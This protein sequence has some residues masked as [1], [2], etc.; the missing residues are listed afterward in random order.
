MLKAH[1]TV[2]FGTFFPSGRASWTKHVRKGKE[3]P[4]IARDDHYDFN[5]QVCE[6]TIYLEKLSRIGGSC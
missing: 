5:F 4:E 6:T 3:L 1:E 2:I